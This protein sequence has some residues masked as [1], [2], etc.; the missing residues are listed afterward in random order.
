MVQREEGSVRRERG[1]CFF[2]VG[3]AEI[4]RRNMKVPLGR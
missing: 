3:C 4:D 2:F 1:D